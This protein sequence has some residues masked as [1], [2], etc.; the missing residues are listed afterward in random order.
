[1]VSGALMSVLPNFIKYPLD[2]R[3]CSES[4]DTSPTQDDSSTINDSFVTPENAL[5]AMGYLEVAE[6]DEFQLQHST[7]NLE[8]YTPASPEHYPREIDEALNYFPP[9]TQ[10]GK[11]VCSNL[12]EAATCIED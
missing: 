7:G 4:L 2:K 3:L 11:S 12:T 8:P 9:K 6:L 5:K 10:T 1:M